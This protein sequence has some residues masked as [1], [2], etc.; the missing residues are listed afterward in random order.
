M[1]AA[2]G[3]RHRR[4]GSGD[5]ATGTERNAAMGE[6]TGHRMPVLRVRPHRVHG[7]RAHGLRA[8]GLRATGGVRWAAA[9]AALVTLGT[10]C[11][12]SAGTGS[13]NGPTGTPPPANAAA[14]TG[15][16]TPTP[17][18]TLRVALAN[19]ID[20]LNPVQARWSLDGNLVGSAIFDTLLT[21]DKDRKLVPR[22]AESVTPNADGTEWTIKLR[23]NLTFHNGEPLDAAAVKLNIDTRKSQPLTGGALEPIN[24]TTATDAQTVKVTMSKPWFGYDYT[25]AAQ[26]GYMVAPAQIAAGTNS[27]KIAIGAGPFKL[28]GEYSEGQPITVQR[29]PD[30]WGDKPYL[31]GIVFS[32]ITDDSARLSSLKGETF[33]LIF[34]QDPVAIREL[35]S[36]P[37]I[38]QVEDVAA[39]EAFAMLNMS[40][41]PFDNIHA[42]K[43]LAYATNR[44]AVVEALNATDIKEPADGPYTDGEQFHST[45]SGYPGVDLAKAAEEIELYKR[46]TGASSL[47]FTF[48][49]STGEKTAMEA[50]QQQWMAVGMEVELEVLEQT[51]FLTKAFTATFQAASFRN[52]AYVNPDSNYIFWHSSQAKGSAGSI[53]FP[54]LKS[55]ALD[56]ALD[57][58]RAT[59]DQAARTEQYKKL[60]PIL[61]ESFTYI[62]LYHNDWALAAAEKVG[63]LNVPRE[64]GFARQDAKPIWNK[65]WIQS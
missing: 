63:G 41:P 33:D 5:D 10:A 58:A 11:S 59:N 37:G 6:T 38:E 49:G 2:P 53:N 20:G 35:R 55:E 52:F 36:T 62:W 40:A 50:A 24:S 25:L 51:A 16:G 23:P 57:T 26:G 12:S 15:E 64:L 21:F 22:L 28:V 34:T 47:S 3:G 30:Y 18:G 46:D 9:A 48:S 31:D 17:G 42:R 45:E 27:M 13:G 4:N 54:Q 29:N 32:A 60:T 1:L 65:I 8:H 7:L 19:A 14:P 39:E 43:A 61:N 56:K 44:E